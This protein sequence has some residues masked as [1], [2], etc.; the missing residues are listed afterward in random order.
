MSNASSLVP[1]STW[2]YKTSTSL[3]VALLQKD[4][5]IKIIKNGGIKVCN[6]LVWASLTWK[7]LYQKTNYNF[8]RSL[9]APSNNITFTANR[10][11]KVQQRR[12]SNKVEPKA[13]K[14]LEKGGL[15]FQNVLLELSVSWSKAAGLSGFGVKLSDCYKKN[16]AKANWFKTIFPTTWNAITIIKE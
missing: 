13:Y 2:K 6:K 12:S 9:F 11:R 1:I 4:N 14:Y 3:S 15:T 5:I 10:R 8:R 16:S 7:R